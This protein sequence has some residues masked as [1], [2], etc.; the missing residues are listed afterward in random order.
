ML[1]VTHDRVLR[2]TP[3]RRKLLG[4]AGSEPDPYGPRIRAVAVIDLQCTPARRNPQAGL[5]F[6]HQQFSGGPVQVG[7]GGLEFRPVPMLRM[8]GENPL[9]RPGVVGSRRNKYRSASVMI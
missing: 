1:C 3:A 5:G 7:D 4:I 6:G 9:Q 8:L 2:R